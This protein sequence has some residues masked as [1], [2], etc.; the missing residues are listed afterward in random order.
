LDIPRPY[1]ERSTYIS[2]FSSESDETLAAQQHP[3]RPESIYYCATG[4]EM[5][6]FEPRKEMKGETDI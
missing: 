1:L 6:V 2:T 3:Q 4:V 5:P